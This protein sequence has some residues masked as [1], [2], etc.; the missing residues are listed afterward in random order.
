[1]SP[2]N[3]ENISLTTNKGTYGYTSR[4]IEIFCNIL[5]LKTHGPQS[6]QDPDIHRDRNRLSN[7]RGKNEPRIRNLPCKA[8][9][10]EI[11]TQK[12]GFVLKLDW[13]N[14]CIAYL[15]FSGPDAKIA[16]GRR[17]ALSC[18]Q[19]SLAQALEKQKET[20]WPKSNENAPLFCLL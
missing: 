7:S 3:R 17:W 18:D 4:F 2:I 1:M 20:M 6:D 14:Q 19:M 11:V 15:L 12:F 5:Y 16:S 9:S 10:L 8:I 13:T